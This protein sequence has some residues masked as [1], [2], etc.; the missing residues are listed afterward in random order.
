[1]RTYRK[2]EVVRAGFLECPHCHSCRFPDERG[3]LRRLRTPK[4]DGARGVCSNCSR[5]MKIIFTTRKSD[6]FLTALAI[7]A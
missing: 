4:I 6:E 3:V 7:K 5:E 2:K 1:M